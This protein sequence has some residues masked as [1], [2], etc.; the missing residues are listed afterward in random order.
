[1]PVHLGHHWRPTAV[2]LV[3]GL[4]SL[5]GLVAWAHAADGAKAKDTDLQALQADVDILLALQGL[6]AMPEQVEQI[7]GILEEYTKASADQRRRLDDALAP[8]ADLMQA[9]RDTVL[10]GRTPA[11]DALNQYRDALRTLGGTARE[12]I[13]L[14]RDT[15]RRIGEVFTPEQ[16]QALMDRMGS[17]G[18]RGG[19]PIGAALGRL[20]QLSDDEFSRRKVD[21]AKSLL[22]AT[23][24]GEDGDGRIAKVVEVFERVRE[25][26]DDQ[27]AA[28]R[29]KLVAELQELGVAARR[30]WR[31]GGQEG[32]PPGGLGGPMPGGPGLGGAMGARR[33]GMAGIVTGLRSAGPEEY[34]RTRE[35]IIA[36]ILARQGLEGEDPERVA[37][38]LRTAMDEIRNAD[39]GQVRA[40]ARAFAERVGPMIGPRGERGMGG[41]MGLGRGPGGPGPLLALAERL[42]DA[43]ERGLELLSG[44]ASAVK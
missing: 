22:G 17:P 1:M 6:K 21:T 40:K 2:A 37:G 7:R 32:P 3:V 10:D 30:G 15:V 29:E 24:F 28:D 33:E 8:S 27:F 35:A 16:V 31:R 14:R 34:E 19:D 26:S 36:R 41:P 38:E 9:L 43:S 39:E 5:G 18:V 44:Y 13:Q 20:R 25:V 4:A 12:G 23:A 11:E 42:I